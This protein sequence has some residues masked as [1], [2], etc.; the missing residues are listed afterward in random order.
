MVENEK[1]KDLAK[2]ISEKGATNPLDS[3]GIT[4]E[5]GKRIVLEGNRRI[6]ALKLLLNPELAPKN[7]KNI[8]IS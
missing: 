6:C 4:I 5:N 2:D 3:V 7:I 8:F 1:V